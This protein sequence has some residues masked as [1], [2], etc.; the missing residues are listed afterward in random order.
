MAGWEALSCLC[1][2]ASPSPFRWIAPRSGVV[3]GL[4]LA[5]GL[6]GLPGPG[7][8]GPGLAGHEPLW[9]RWLGSVVPLLSSRAALAAAA[10]PAV[11][12]ADPALQAVVGRAQQA[13][14]E[15]LARRFNSPASG[16]D[17]WLTPGL[18]IA[19][20]AG[21]AGL[22]DLRRNGLEFGWML[23]E[24]PAP[25]PIGLCRTSGEGRVV[26]IEQQPD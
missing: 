13:C 10:E 5:A 8:P 9:H 15:A 1:P 12:A 16:V 2:M 23:P 19:I 20:E 7:L 22:A 14:R 24:R 17:V 25:A 11:V 21:E 4:V 3:L 26:A 18:R 6:P